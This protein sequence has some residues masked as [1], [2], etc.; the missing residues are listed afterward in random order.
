MKTVGFTRQRCSG[1]P[2]YRRIASSRRTARSS[3]DVER[4][5][6]GTGRVT[7]SVE[8][9]RRMIPRMGSSSSPRWSPMTTSGRSC[10]TLWYFRIWP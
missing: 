9:N 8:K 1:T 6:G 10:S 4:T 5:S 7:T 3:T 2:K